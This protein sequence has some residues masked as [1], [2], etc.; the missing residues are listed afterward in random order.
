MTEQES[1]AAAARVAYEGARALAERDAAHRAHTERLLLAC[2]DALD[3]CDRLLAAGPQRDPAAYRRS[4]RLIARQL[5]SAATGAGLEPLGAVGE[6]ADPATH[7]VVAVRPAPPGAGDDEVLEVARRGY[8]YR[9]HVLRAARVVV[10]AKDRTQAAQEG[11]AQ[12]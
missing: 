4:V 6:R 2:A 5:E 12:G 3:A 11:T 8:R 9:G 1:T 10:A 7:H